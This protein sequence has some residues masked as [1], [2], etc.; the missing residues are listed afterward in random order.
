M[1]DQD[2][3][4]NVAKVIGLI[5]SSF[6]AI[7]IGKL[8]YRNL[9]KEKIEALKK[10]KGNYEA[11]MHVTESMKSEL[12]WWYLNIFTQNRKISHGNPSFIIETDASNLGWGA[13]LGKD[14]IGGQWTNEEK[15]KHINYL[16]LLAIDFALHSFREK[17]KNNH[18]KVLTDN[19]TAVAY[20]NNMG[21]TKSLNCNKISRNIWLWCIENGIWLSCSHIPGKS[22]IEADEKSRLF[23]DQTEWKLKDTIF[24]KITEKWGIPD[25]DLFQKLLGLI[26]KLKNLVPGNQ[27]H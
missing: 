16:E 20:I 19:S 18:V 24:Q 5:V 4:R 9:E 13:V 25:I 14:K 21:G 11:Y 3:I 1:K 8:F 2:K 12:K 22:N 6:S 27:I 7:E 15:E 10:S 23:N 17:I 26:F